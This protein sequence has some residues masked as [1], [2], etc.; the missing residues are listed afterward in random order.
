MTRKARG[1]VRALAIGIAL[2]SAMVRPACA[3]WSWYEDSAGYQYTV[4]RQRSDGGPVLIYFRTDW[5]PHCRTLDQLLESRE[6]T[7]RLKDYLKVRINPEHGARDLGAGQ[8]AR[9]HVHH[10]AVVAREIVGVRHQ[11]RGEQL[12][13]HLGTRVGRETLHDREVEPEPARVAEGAADGGA[14]VVRVAD[15]EAAHRL[16]A[17]LPEEA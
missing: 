12:R 7:S 15:D 6:V 9:A 13:P 10:V 11:S 1:T 17:V 2:A 5:C 8:V 16:D 4:R 14:V 3:S